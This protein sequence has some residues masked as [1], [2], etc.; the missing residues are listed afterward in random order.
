MK[1]GTSIDSSLMNSFNELFESICRSG[2]TRL[3]SSTQLS[4]LL[5]YEEDADFRRRHKYEGII[6]EMKSVR[7]LM[8]MSYFV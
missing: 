8:V 6:E 7:Q 5:A 2:V 1:H 3:K 4:S